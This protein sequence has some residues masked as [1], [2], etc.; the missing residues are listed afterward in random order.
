MGGRARWFGC[1][2]ALALSAA[3]CKTRLWDR[4]SDGG[5]ALDL[6]I[7]RDGLSLPDFA[8]PADLTAPFFCR[9]IYVVD[10]ATQRLS[11]FIPELA[12]FSDV[13]PLNCPAVPGATPDTMSVDLSGRAWVG[14]T[15]GSI[16]T[17]DLTTAECTPTPFDPTNISPDQTTSTSWQPFGSSFSLDQ[18]N[19]V[20]ETL[21]IA[22]SND[23][24]LGSID[25]LTFQWKRGPSLPDYVEMTGTAAAELWAYAP[26]T[27]PSYIARVDKLTGALDSK[28]VLPQMQTFGG[29]AFAFWGGSFWIFLG[30]GPDTDP[31]GSGDTSVYRVDRATGQFTTALKNTH[32]HIVGAGVSGCA[33]LGLDR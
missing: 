11:G 5:S 6:A 3:S 20:T 27:T 26:E 10:E 4:D 18:P 13:G 16:F 19:G 25:P 15:N 7:P 22:L 9:P 32:R 28:I 14:Y 31:Q 24:V 1:V 30:D 29:F 8:P 17:V 21:Y 23:R 12:Q 2:A 33:P